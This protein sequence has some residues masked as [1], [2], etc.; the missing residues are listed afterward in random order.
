MWI[1]SRRPRKRDFCPGQ[2]H[3]GLAPNWRRFPCLSS[4]PPSLSL[5]GLAP[6][7]KIALD[8]R[9]GYRRRVLTDLIEALHEDAHEAG[10]MC[11]STA[12]GTPLTT[13]ASPCVTGTCVPPPPGRHFAPSNAILPRES[14]SVALRNVGGVTMADNIEILNTAVSLLVRAA[15]LA[16]RFSRRVRQQSLKLPT[17]IDL[18]A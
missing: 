13:A 14:A 8:R 6:W 9:L 17:T 4:V 15:L 18:S 3:S 7:V 11:L 5:P 16:A 2:V 12:N 10:A 1:E